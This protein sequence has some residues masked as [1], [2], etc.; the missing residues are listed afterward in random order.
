LSS[1]KPEKARVRVIGA[2]VLDIFSDTAEF[3]LADALAVASLTRA[4]LEIMDQRIDI[5]LGN[6]GISLCVMFGVEKAGFSDGFV[7]A[8]QRFHSGPCLRCARATGPAFGRT[9]IRRCG[10]PLQYLCP[11][12]VSSNPRFYAKDFK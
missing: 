4:F 5:A 9:G 11:P 12:P 10:C 3:G 2:D 7:I 8:E 6:I 1:M